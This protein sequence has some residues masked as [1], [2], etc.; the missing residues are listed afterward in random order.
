MVYFTFAA[1]DDEGEGR[2]AGWEVREELEV[3]RTR[4]SSI[5]MLLSC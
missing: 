1:D 5:V 3:R 2:T 4:T